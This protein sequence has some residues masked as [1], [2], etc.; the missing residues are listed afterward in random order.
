MAIKEQLEVVQQGAK[1]WNEWREVNDGLDYDLSG[2]NLV[3]VDLHRANLNGI[4]L[5]SANLSNA[6]LFEAQ[7]YEADLSGANLFGAHLAGSDFDAVQVE[8]TIFGNLDL[9]EVLGLE[10]V[11]HYG[12]SSI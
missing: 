12:P 9:S 2:A 5:S 8:D 10:H 6:N 7:L 11:D 4:N 1:V 3:S